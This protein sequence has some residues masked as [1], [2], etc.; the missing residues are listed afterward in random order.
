MRKIKEK[1]ILPKVGFL[2][3]DFPS[4]II[5]DHIKGSIWEYNTKE[6]IKATCVNCIDIPCKV[7]SEDE[8]LIDEF[9]S[10]PSNSTLNV[11]PSDA[12]E[13]FN[14]KPVITPSK[15]TSCGICI[16][17][18]IYN[19]ISINKTESAEICHDSNEKIK[20]NELE[21]KFDHYSQNVLIES[22]LKDDKSSYNLKIYSKTIDK[23]I[24]AYIKK[25]NNSEN[26]IIRNILLNLGIKTNTRAIGNNSIRIDLWGKQNDYYL[27]SEIDI[28]G[29]DLLDLTRAILDDIAIL[30][31]RYKISKDKIIPMIIIDKFP[32]KR[33]DYYEV[34][35]DI[36][37]IT[38]I[39]IMTITLHFLLVMQWLK[40][41]FKLENYKDKFIVK[42]NEESIMDACLSIIPDLDKIDPEF[43]SEYYWAIK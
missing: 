3:P 8:F 21:S 1:N 16:Q 10:M 42:K 19:A 27:I 40:I 6:Q 14:N 36:E 9:K 23:K 32:N 11:C 34:I 25:N 33:S 37:D 31:S 28:G 2:T 7:Y 24:I 39:K 29:L 38:G 43:F 5:I 35:K 26:T 12:F 30:H 20:F 17:R 4:K 41:E 18:C 22:V 13:I 15:C